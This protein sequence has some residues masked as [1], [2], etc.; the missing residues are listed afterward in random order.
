MD[1][2]PPNPQPEPSDEAWRQIEKLVEEI[3]DLSRSE[4]SAGEFYKELLGRVVSGLAA[5]AATV[6]TRAAGGELQPRY[7]I[8]PPDEDLSEGDQRWPGR[9]RLIEAVLADGKPRLVP[10]RSS[11]ADDGPVENPTPYLLALCPWSVDDELAGVIEVFQRPGASP[12]VQRG[13]VEFLSVIC[14]LVTDFHRNRQVRTFQARAAGWRRFEQYVAAVHGS[15][16]L[17]QTAYQIANEGRRLIDCDRLS[18]LIVHRSKCRLAAT[19][20]VDTPN[21]R[22]N[23]VRQLERLAAAVAA[24]NE[25]LWYGPGSGEL[26]P[27]IERPLGAYVDETHVRLLAAVPLEMTETDAAE[28]DGRRP[29]G[30]MVV[31]RFHGTEDDG[32]RERVDAACR[33]GAIAL[34]NALELR[35]VPFARSLRMLGT[36][37][38]LLRGRRL[39]KTLCAVAILAAV[40]IVLATVPADFDVEARGELQPRSRHD[41]FAPADGVV[42]GLQVAHGDPVRAGDPLLT[43]RKPEFDLE[44]QRVWGELQTAQ[45]RLAAIE[46]QR[47]PPIPAVDRRRRGTQAMGRKSEAAIRDR[48]T[49]AGGAGD[50]QPDR[51]PRAH[52]ERQAT[53]RG[54]SG[55]PGATPGYGGRVESGLGPGTRSTRRPDRRRAGGPTADRP[56]CRRFVRPGHRTGRRLPGTDRGRG[57][58]GGDRRIAAVGGA[59]NGPLRPR[60]RSEI[61]PGC[62]RGGQDPLRPAA[63]RIRVA[64]RPVRGRAVV[65]V[66]LS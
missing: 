23:T 10:P 36:A 59:G 40:L 18:V 14:E 20:G 47:P 50:P 60:R 54:T 25:P 66:V 63:G 19:S 6:W 3:A 42:S 46:A 9:G 41:L 57:A 16:D 65:G 64:A 1:S 7:R 8:D 62:D 33:H 11:A 48:A 43:L 22:A 53:A 29:L 28:H 61:D 5:P 2:A 49:T 12:Q 15:L 35:S 26:P 52:L 39:P 17:R 44:Y 31:E 51:R 45:Q 21:R 32:L 4:I 34:Q 13:Y 37:A 38:G 56:P 55:P 58:P 24:C 27:P 30:V